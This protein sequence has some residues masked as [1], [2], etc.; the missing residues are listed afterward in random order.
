MTQ[1]TST[2]G[3]TSNTQIE[4]LRGKHK[5]KTGELVYLWRQWLVILPGK[6]TLE[7]KAEPSPRSF[8]AL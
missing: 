2:T 8:R 5:G 7:I 1:K 6:V 4:V 3:F